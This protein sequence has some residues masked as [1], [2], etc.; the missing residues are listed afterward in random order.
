MGKFDEL[1]LEIKLTRAE[2][3]ILLHLKKGLNIKAIAADM[4]IS[5]N[6]VRVHIARIHK[7]LGVNNQ[8]DTLA[9][10]GKYHLLKEVV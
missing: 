5:P 1:I 2:K 9:M 3:M 8:A 10:A 6:T 7:K 4:N